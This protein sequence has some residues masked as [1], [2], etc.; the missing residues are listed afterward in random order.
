[1]CI[2]TDL[3]EL[4]AIR[5]SVALRSCAARPLTRKYSI[6]FEGPGDDGTL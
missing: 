6:K 1:M 3:T 4:S 2:Y 5:A